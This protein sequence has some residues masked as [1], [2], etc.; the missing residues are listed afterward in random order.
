V[1][2]TCKTVPVIEFCTSLLPLISE[3]GRKCE[4][5]EKKAIIQWA[6]PS[7]YSNFKK[8][9]RYLEL[10][11]RIDPTAEEKGLM[12]EIEKTGDLRPFLPK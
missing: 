12:A 3:P 2:F 8:L 1:D 5:G 10:K 9:T 7:R 4:G 11:E 6:P